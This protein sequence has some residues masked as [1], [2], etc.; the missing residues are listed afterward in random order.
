LTTYYPH[1]D[2]LNLNDLIPSQHTLILMETTRL[3]Y[4]LVLINLT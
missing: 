2:R 1:L 4:D 3:K